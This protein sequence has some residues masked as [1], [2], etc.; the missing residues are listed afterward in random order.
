MII[1]QDTIIKQIAEKEDV[2]VATVRQV[3][4]SAEDIIFDYLSSIAP[5]EAITIKLLKGLSID[6]KYIKEK[7]Y[8]K[9]MFQ[10]INCPEHVRHRANISKY[11][12]NKVNDILFSRK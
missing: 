10:N 12:T 2:D 6:R 8:S 3:F 7:K 1:T 4:K 9:G 11:F 5:S